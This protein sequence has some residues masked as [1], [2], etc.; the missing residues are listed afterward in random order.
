MTQYAKINKS[1]LYLVNYIQMDIIYNFIF[2]YFSVLR[3]FRL[4]FL[5]IF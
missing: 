2:V 5:F 1:I 3:H 4:Y